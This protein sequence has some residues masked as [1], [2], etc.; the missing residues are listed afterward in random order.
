MNAA[1][2]V[3][4]HD[5]Q[6]YPTVGD[7]DFNVMAKGTSLEQTQVDIYVSKMGNEDYEFLVGIHELIEAYLCRKRGISEGSVTAFD[8][9]FESKRPSGNTDEPGCDPAAPYYK[10]HLYAT[11]IEKQIS[12]ELNVSWSEYEKTI[13][14]L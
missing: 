7:W 14:A 1:I 4:D 5:K 13:N 6:R 2:T 11:G 9:E 8:I 12:T 10:E 3:I